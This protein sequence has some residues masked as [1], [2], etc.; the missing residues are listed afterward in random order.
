MTTRVQG[1]Y[2]GCTRDVKGLYKGCTRDAQRSISHATPEQPR[3]NTLAA[4][5]IQTRGHRGWPEPPKRPNGLP[6]LPGVDGLP[7]ELWL[8]QS[9]VVPVTN[10]VT[11]HEPARL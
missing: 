2:K 6:R 11:Y 9:L 1:I 5:L 7:Y 4:R 8:R 3:S 10:P